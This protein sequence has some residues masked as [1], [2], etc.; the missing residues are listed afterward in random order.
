MNPV[1]IGFFIGIPVGCIVLAGILA[2]IHA[3]RLWE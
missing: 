2:L 1:L 3:G